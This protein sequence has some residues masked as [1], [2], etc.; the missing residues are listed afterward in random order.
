MRFGTHFELGKTENTCS[1]NCYSQQFFI[2]QTCPGTIRFGPV[3]TDVFVRPQTFRKTRCLLE[4]TKARNAIWS[5]VHRISNRDHF[6]R[7]F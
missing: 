6:S 4:A 1:N 5:W 3:K 7:P 2:V